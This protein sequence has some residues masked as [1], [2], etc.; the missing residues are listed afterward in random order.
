MLF[1]LSL[2]AGSEN[3]SEQLK[4]LQAL[5]K[6]DLTSMERVCVRRS[7]EQHKLGTNRT[8]LGQVRDLLG[9]GVGWGGTY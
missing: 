6:E 9:R 4:E 8:L 7:I 2:H 3:A 5:M 1:F